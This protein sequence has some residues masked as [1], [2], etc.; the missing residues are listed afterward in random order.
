MPWCGKTGHKASNCNETPLKPEEQARIRQ[1]AA[2][3]CAA[4][5]DVNRRD[6]PLSQ[7]LG[8][9]KKPDSISTP[10]T[11]DSV[12]GRAAVHFVDTTSE[13]QEEWDGDIIEL[14][15]VKAATID[16]ARKSMFQVYRVEEGADMR[17]VIAQA[18]AGGTVRLRPEWTSDEGNQAGPSKRQHTEPRTQSRT[19]TP[20]VDV[21]N[22]ANVP[23]PRMP[24]EPQMP[25]RSI[26]GLDG[27]RLNVKEFLNKTQTTISLAQ[28]CDISPAIRAE[29]AH[30]L[31]LLPDEKKKKAAKRAKQN[32]SGIRTHADTLSRGVP[33]AA[34]LE[35]NQ[36][37]DFIIR[38]MWSTPTV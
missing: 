3:R 26:Y 16:E 28:L 10:E 8:Q 29:F 34:G 1:A 22:P 9:P 4:R 32:K 19:A 5:F 13:S 30:Q 7:T 15:R 33:N 21:P 25:K 18:Y 14:P 11:T 12:P 36:H 6:P 31:T 23:Q 37:V 2:I 35:H 24:G 27:P 38:P 20:E 17:E